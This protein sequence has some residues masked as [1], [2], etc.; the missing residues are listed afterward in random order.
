MTKRTAILSLLAG[1]AAVLLALTTAF[2]TPSAMVWSRTATAASLIERGTWAIDADPT[3][4][5]NV[6]KVKVGNSFYS[7]KPPLLALLMSAVYWPLYHLGFR[8]ESGFNLVYIS[9]VFIL[10]GG[11]TLLCLYCFFRCLSFVSAT[12]Q[13]RLTMTAALGF[14]TLLLPW[15]TVMNSHAFSGAWV[16]ITF[17]LLFSAKLQT[18]AN[19]LGKIFAAGLSVG[20]AASS[21]TSSMLFVVTFAVYLLWCTPHRKYLPVY[22]AAAGL[23]ML[24]GIVISHGITGDFRPMSVHAE[25]FKYP[26]SHWNGASEHLS[27]AAPNSAGFA[28]R[29]A[30]RCLA[31]PNGFLLYNPLLLLALFGIFRLVSRRLPFWQEAFLAFSASS[32]FCAYFFVYSS[33]YGG[34]SYSIR[35]FVTL[36]PLLWFFAFPFFE[37]LTR[38]KTLLFRALAASGVLIALA[39]SVDQWPATLKYPDTPAIVLNARKILA[40]TLRI[41]S[42]AHIIPD[43]ESS[44]G[45]YR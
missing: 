30:L 13:T 25:L 38:A 41:A 8:L 40:H 6:D 2:H 1:L 5:E 10:I 18:G 15:S 29:Y 4:P 31:G 7:D 33:N 14:C 39:G 12:V 23:V 24:P 37:N 44:V 20:L 42:K 21:D 27:G 45:P 34:F 16:F 19:V 17:Y 3:T 43:A 36:V 35:W 9:S 11:S 26:G 22:L 32:I 28:L